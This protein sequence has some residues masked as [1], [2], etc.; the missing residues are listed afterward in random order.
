MMQVSA[1]AVSLNRLIRIEGLNERKGYH[2][3]RCY[4]TG[5][6]S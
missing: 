2:A 5:E 3:G 1:P 6:E 4:V